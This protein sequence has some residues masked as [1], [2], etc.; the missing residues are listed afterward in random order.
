MEG[1]L[2]GR[3]GARR[4]Q[5]HIAPSLGQAAA[6]RKPAP[7]ASHPT[8]APATPCFH[9]PEASY[10]PPPVPVVVQDPDGTVTVA[11]RARLG[12]RLGRRCGL[13]T[14][15]WLVQQRCGF[16]WWTAQTGR[17]LQVPLCSPQAFLLRVSNQSYLITQ[18]DE[19]AARCAPGAAPGCLHMCRSDSEQHDWGVT[20]W[21]HRYTLTLTLYPSCTLH[22]PAP[23]PQP[24]R[25][26][27]GCPLPQ[28][29]HQP[30]RQPLAQPAH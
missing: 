30:A 20:N 13:A 25:S 26:G 19:E 17:P 6:P 8:R 18:G 16:P 24:H 12:A 27:H 7:A 3:E 5:M 23:L 21:G 15:A 10:H 22:P 9:L 28:P 4:S 2:G 1:E 11:S 14:R 29:A